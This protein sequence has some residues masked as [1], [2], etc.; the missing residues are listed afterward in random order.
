MDLQI[1]YLQSEQRKRQEELDVLERDLAKQLA[2][3]DKI[4]SRECINLIE[5]PALKKK[6]KE[7]VRVWKRAMKSKNLTVER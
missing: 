5:D 7:F 1:L 4:T 2:F 6:M 3:L